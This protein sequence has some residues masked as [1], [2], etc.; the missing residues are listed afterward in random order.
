MREQ[1]KE[2]ISNPEKIQQNRIL[3]GA[4][5]TIP[6]GEAFKTLYE[7]ILYLI[8]NVELLDQWSAPFSISHPDLTTN[9][10]LV[11][12][13]DPARVVGII[14]WEGTRIQPWV[15]S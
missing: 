14:D 3:N 13:E 1:I 10:I 6:D 11:S 4:E 8:S 9:N 12:Y 7:S 15:R 2:L 5:E